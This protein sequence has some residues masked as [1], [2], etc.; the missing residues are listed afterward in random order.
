MGILD[1]FGLNKEK[2][3][4][5]VI[6]KN[7]QERWCLDTYSLWCS[8]A[9]GDPSKVGG[10]FSKKSATVVLKRDWAVDIFKGC[11]EKFLK[12]YIDPVIAMKSESKSELAWEYSCCGQLLCLG[13]SA[14]IITKEQYNK[15]FFQL[16][17]EY[18]R[19]F[20]SWEDMIEAY[21][22]GYENATGNTE[23]ADFRRQV[24]NLL[25]APDTQNFKEQWNLQF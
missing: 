21:F 23:E 5:F 11:D 6:P 2:N 20:T 19:N 4:E 13:Y 8:S 17:K 24:Y 15:Y 7:R 14:E 10:R 18:Q 25:K 22:I 9:G 1:I 16:A 12:E 3:E